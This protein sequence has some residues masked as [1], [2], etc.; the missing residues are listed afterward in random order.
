VQGV[1]RGLCAEI[2]TVY[3]DIQANEGGSKRRRGKIADAGL[4]DLCCFTA[5]FDSGQVLFTAQCDSGQVLFTAHCDDGQ[6][7]FTAH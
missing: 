1:K 6:V 3:W 4:H 2:W 7:L 5:H